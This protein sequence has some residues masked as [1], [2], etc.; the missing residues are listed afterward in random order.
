[1]ALLIA[2]IREDLANQIGVNGQPHGHVKGRDGAV[3]SAPEYR[4]VRMEEVW[5]GP[6]NG[7]AP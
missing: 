2:Y 5:L 7:E 3:K 4:A 6:C 1:M